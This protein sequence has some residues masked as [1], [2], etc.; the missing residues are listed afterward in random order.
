MLESARHKPE[1]KAMKQAW[2]NLFDLRSYSILTTLIVSPRVQYPALVVSSPP[3]G[4]RDL[5]AELAAP[6]LGVLVDTILA[7]KNTANA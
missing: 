3:A 7:A 6:G 2:P 4:P 5:A 1:W